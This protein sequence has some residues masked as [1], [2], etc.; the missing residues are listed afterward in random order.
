MTTYQKNRRGEKALSKAR[1]GDTYYGTADVS[2]WV[3]PYEDSELAVRFT[4]THDHPILGGPMCGSQSLKSALWEHG[5]LYDSKP[6]HL[7][8]VWEPTPQFGDVNLLG[9]DRH[10]DKVELRELAKRNRENRQ[11]QKEAKRRGWM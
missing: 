10:L 4:V 11:L 7:R 3:A 6:S 2:K 5:P 1:K 9:G 8:G